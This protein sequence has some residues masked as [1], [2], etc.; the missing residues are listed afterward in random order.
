MRKALA[1]I[2]FLVFLVAPM[3][4]QSTKAKPVQ[5]LF[6]VAATDSLLLV[7]PDGTTQALTWNAAQFCVTPDFVLNLCAPPPPSGRPPARVSAWS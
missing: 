2:A 7:H 1:L 3:L 6:P 4:A 5:V